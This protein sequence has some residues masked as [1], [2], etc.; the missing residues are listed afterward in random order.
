MPNR[1]RRTASVLVALFGAALIL[2]SCGG[3]PSAVAPRR[4]RPAGTSSPTAA[5]AN[6]TSPSSTAA[7]A[8]PTSSSTSAPTSTTAAVAAASTT[9]P[10]SAPTSSVAAVPSAS[11]TE[12]V[13]DLPQTTALPS[14]NSPQ[15]VAAMHALFS[16]I[17][18]GVARRAMVAFFPESAYL[19]LKA[20]S[21]PAADYRSRLVADYD[22]D[23]AA[24]HRFLGPA[25]ARASFAAVTVPAGEAAWI[26]PGYC[27]NSIGYWHDPG[28]R[29]DY[30]VGGQLRS[31]GIASLI[32]WRGEW[33]VV[34]LGAVLR[35]SGGGIVDSPAVGA[36]VPGA[37]GGC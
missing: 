5:A 4:R 24:A 10:E 2:S 9:R 3:Q 27:Y 34:H 22:A 30:R 16:A 11:P 26:P 12:A 13:G 36:G 6:S 33:Y 20:I 37:P 14:G 7:A 1:H 31:I 35:S 8:S 29:L 18:S 21:D 28:A 32:S 15:F 19:R 23:I 25:A 17:S